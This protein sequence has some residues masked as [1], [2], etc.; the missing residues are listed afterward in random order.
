MTR[1]APPTRGP[2]EPSAARPD[3]RSTRVALAVLAAALLFA[4]RAAFGLGTRGADSNALDHALFEPSMMTPGIALAAFAVLAWHRRD[5]IA[6]AFSAGQ[7][8]GWGASI[9]AVGIALLI[10]SRQIEAD[11]LLVP[12]LILHS[13]GAA[14][15][16]GGRPLLRTL[17][18]PLLALATAIALPPQWVQAIV[19]P[20]QLWTVSTSSALLDLL[21]RS[22]EVLGDFVLYR[23]DRFQVI[24]GCSG[25]KTI[26]SLLLAAIAYADLVVRGPG[27]KG[28]LIA[29][30]IPIGI[31]ANGIRVVGLILGR[32]SSETI[33]H[34]AYGIF[35]IVGGV[36]AL[37][38]T[39]MSLTGIHA[40]FRGRPKLAPAGPPRSVTSPMTYSA[41]PRSSERTARASSESGSGRTRAARVAQVSGLIVLS[42]LASSVLPR[43][44]WRAPSA[45]LNIETL[46]ETI[47][48]RTAR[49]LP[50]DDAWLGSVRFGHRIY[51]SYD[52]DPSSRDGSIRVF[53]GHE[54]VGSAEQSGNAARTAIPRSGWKRI[55]P[56]AAIEIGSD[57][58]GSG[59]WERWAIDY[60][61]QR[62]LVQRWATGFAPWGLESLVRWFGLDRAG[63]MGTRRSPLVIRVELDASGAEEDLDWLIVR[64]FST[65]I[66][67]WAIGKP[68]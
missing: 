21:G 41:S 30:A 31:L 13:I 68:D 35:A 16:I 53:V 51:R 24:E 2:S 1:S 4:H 64:Q 57:A 43:G 10:W 18:L 37:A 27:M 50:V 14:V 3:G 55:A 6:A 54:D 59:R 11:R 66:E 63:L 62:V 32:I 40:G 65:Q 26:V 58:G 33:E 36:V 67:A 61:D 12:S 49:P 42:A 45:D 20:L 19:L 34:T 28:L 44:T 22:H 47:E 23:G 60:P 5:R 48:G 29:L 46:P 7:G 8:R 39:E 38:V 9:L 25:F 56:R 15:M 17:G 52:A